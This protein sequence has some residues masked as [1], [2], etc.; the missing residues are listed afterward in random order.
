MKSSGLFRA[1]APIFSEAAARL[2]NSATRNAL[3]T[4]I[5][6]RI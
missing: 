4:V 1:F 3:G 2:G 6:L 5:L